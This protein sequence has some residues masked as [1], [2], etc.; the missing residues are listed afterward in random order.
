MADISFSTTYYYDQKL[1]QLQGL[2]SE[3]YGDWTIA[4]VALAFE[5]ANLTAEEHASQYAAVEGLNVSPGLDTASYLQAKLEQLQTADAAKYGEWTVEDV[6]AAFQDAGL[7][8]LEHYNTYGAAEG[9][10]ATPVSASELTEALKTLQS[11]EQAKE[12]FL[13]AAASNEQVKA[14]LSGDSEV[15]NGDD[16]AEVAANGAGGAENPTPADIE[17][18]IK[19]AAATASENLEEHR[20]TV[21][22]DRVIEAELADT[23]DAVTAYEAEIAKV[24][25]LEQAVAAKSAAEAQVKTATKAQTEADA[26][27]AGAVVTFDKLNESS[28]TIAYLNGEG[29]EA[30]TFSEVASITDGTNELFTVSNGKL[31]AA[32]EDSVKG[33][34]ALQA[35]VQAKLDAE[36][37]LEE[38]NAADEAANATLIKIEDLSDGEFAGLDN[39]AD[40]YD[41]L[42]GLEKDVKKAQAVVDERAELV[43][44]ADAAGDLAGELKA[45][46][47]AITDAEEALTD[48]EA[49]GG[50]GVNLVDLGGTGTAEDD[51]FVFSAGDDTS[52]DQF[53]VAGDDSIYV[54]DGFTR[55]DLAADADFADAQGDVA[56]ME[57]FFQ[58]NGSDAVLTFEDKAFAASGSSAS[59]DLTEVTLTGVNVEDLS[60]DNGYINVA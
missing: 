56:T 32:T 11:A 20:D 6:A 27:L 7:S 48:D 36:I 58:Q 47:Q 42:G 8:P 25:G 31:T 2:D 16:G 46:N 53:G 26:D 22:S 17:D 39:G 23:Q 4:D 52:T 44:K 49:D 33:V 30:E 57:V 3:K 60:I 54:G 55:V 12:D 45:V 35:A 34:A 40:V 10:K 5:R 37:D 18:A 28:S 9:L 50:F 21:G 1:A 51:L 29:G 38:A 19:A 14:A 13:T 43:E 41:E 59:Q 15:A 24:E